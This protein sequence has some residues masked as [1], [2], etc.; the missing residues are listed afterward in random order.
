MFLQLG[1]GDVEGGL[2]RIIRF[3]DDRGGGAVLGHMAVDTI[4]RDIQRAI[5][6]PFDIHRIE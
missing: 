1:I 3:P 5:L 2:I 4:G 6:E